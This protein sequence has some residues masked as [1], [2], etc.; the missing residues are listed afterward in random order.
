M[1][2]SKD[3]GRRFENEVAAKLT[4]NGIP[5]ERIP[6][7][8]SFGGKYNCDVVIG[9]PEEPIAKIECKYRESISK[10]LWEWFEQG[11][12]S[13]YLAIKRNF[14]K[15]LILMD[16]EQFINLLK[17]KDDDKEKEEQS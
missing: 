4:D 11:D 15:P 7:S 2:K 5:A 16:M 10:Q 6:L 13:D 9:T 8:G 14:H 3:K 17:G 1:S 12:G